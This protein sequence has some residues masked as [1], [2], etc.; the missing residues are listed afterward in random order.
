MTAQTETH[1]GTVAKVW[2]HELSDGTGVITAFTLDGAPGAFWM[3]SD[4]LDV[5][6]EA[7][8]LGTRCRVVATL[9]DDPEPCGDPMCGDGCCDDPD[10]TNVPAEERARPFLLRADTVEWL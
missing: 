8:K 4:S 3:G 6:L 10:C 2:P 5:L 7:H 1:T 9:P